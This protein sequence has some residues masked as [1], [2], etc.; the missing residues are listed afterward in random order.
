MGQ[1]LEGPTIDMMKEDGR[2]QSVGDETM[3]ED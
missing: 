3:E 2:M 1:G